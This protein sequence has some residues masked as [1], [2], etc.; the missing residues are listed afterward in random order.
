MNNRIYLTKIST[1]ILRPLCKNKYQYEFLNKMTENEISVY[2]KEIKNQLKKTKIP[3][4]EYNKLK[5]QLIK[6]REEIYQ[7]FKLIG[8]E[9]EILMPKYL[10]DYNKI[11]R[12]LIDKV[13]EDSKKIL[14]LDEWIKAKQINNIPLYA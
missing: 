14:T 9:P 5:D 7:I 3:N 4:D 6:E 11:N 8:E 1:L 10:I 13:Y 12:E 2:F